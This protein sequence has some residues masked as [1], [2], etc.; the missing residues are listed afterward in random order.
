ME[1]SAPNLRL[2]SSEAPERIDAN[3]PQRRDDLSFESKL[4]ECTAW[5]W[6]SDGADAEPCIVLA[7]GVDVARG[8]RRD[9]QLAEDSRLVLLQ[10][11]EHLFRPEDLDLVT[12]AVLSVL[13]DAP[14]VDRQRFLTTVLIT[15]IVESTQIAT[16]LGDRRW[17]QALG[18]HYAQCRSQI[19]ERGGTL[20]KTTGD[21]VVASFDSPARA[22]R[23]GMAIQASAR[24]SGLAVRAGVHAGECERLG[25]DLAGVAV[26]IAARMCA[27]AGADEV[28]ATGTVRDLV[29]GSMLAFEP[30]GE[31]AFKGVPG[32]WTVFRATDPA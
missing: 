2:I 31:Q 26:H 9:T 19:D 4:P 12:G 11:P 24:R 7:Y 3:R 17:R 28:M 5:R 8:P 14:R 22:V 23:A 6:Q 13:G 15:D 20:V 21:G 25:D 27:L 30:R 16:R 32:S 10:G 18:D 1:H 29:T